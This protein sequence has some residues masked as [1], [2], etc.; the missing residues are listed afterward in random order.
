M[1]S[2]LNHL[3]THRDDFLE[4]LFEFLRIPSVSAQTEHTEDARRAAEYVRARLDAL[5]FE[6]GLFSGDGLPTVFATRI[7]DPAK[8][9]LLVY[10]HYD[11][12]PPEPLDLWESPPFEPTLVNGEIRARGC[13]DD[14]GPTLALLL[15]A[16]CWIRST[17]ALPVNLKV[18]IEGEEESGGKVV[19]Q[20]L[21]AHKS[22]LAAGALVI[23]DLPAVSA[24]TPSL[25]YGL[26]GLAAAE[27]IVHGPSR[28]L[29]SGLYGGTVANPASALARLIASLHDDTGRVAIE[30][31][32]EGVLEVDEAERERLAKRPFSEAEHLAETGSPA[33]FGEPGF[34]TLERMGAR[35]TC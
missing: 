23:A 8:P 7:E 31:F 28:D 30:G 34:S 3:E 18:V 14:K 6:T 25:C 2:A 16:E 17:G 11:V 19:E 4:A 26:R 21:R 15:A 12:Q 10:G 13:A 1:Q 32:Y 35:P 5:G 22:D 9:T 27:V 24:D 29:H 20:F 33:L